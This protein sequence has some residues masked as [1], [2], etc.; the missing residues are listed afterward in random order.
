MHGDDAE[1]NKRTMLRHFRNLVNETALKEH[2]VQ[3]MIRKD[4]GQAKTGEIDQQ[5]SLSEAEMKPIDVRDSEVLDKTVVLSAEKFHMD[6]TSAQ[7]KE[8]HNVFSS[9]AKSSKQEIALS[10]SRLPAPF[11]CS[12]EDRIANSNCE[13]GPSKSFNTQ[14][15]DST[16][17]LVAILGDGVSKEDAASLL[18]LAN[19]DLNA[20][21]NLYYDNGTRSDKVKGTSRPT[22]F[23]KVVGVESVSPITRKSKRTR[24]RQGGK[25]SKI[26]KVTQQAAITTFFA[27]STKEKESHC[28]SEFLDNNADRECASD[29]RNTQNKPMEEKIK[30]KSKR[31]EG[32]QSTDFA[33]KPDKEELKS[34]CVQSD[35]EKGEN[36][37]L[38][39]VPTESSSSFFDSRAYRRMKRTSE[40]VDPMDSSTSGILQQNVQM[41]NDASK[42]EAPVNLSSEKVDKNVDN[43]E[44]GYQPQEERTSGPAGNS[45]ANTEFV[46]LP[47]SQYNPVTMACWKSGEPTPYLHVALSL[48][49][50]DSTT[51]RLRISDALTNMFRSV[52]SLGTMSELIQVTYLTCGRISS[53]YEGR[54]LVKLSDDLCT[55]KFT[56]RYLKFSETVLSESEF[57]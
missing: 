29:K 14:S 52:L 57:V 15:L 6:D 10:D 3:A 51:K 7:Q 30:L 41:E 42:T 11:E 12:V 16:I 35:H 31:D 55:N 23:R 38:P 28:Q 53:E 32:D 47:V 50:I 5:S 48:A 20:A 36:G 13:S 49:S 45:K 37:G 43:E 22:I 4:S 40:H 2:F 9:G 33:S 46:M 19:Y 26:S 56:W 54:T 39:N 1:K 34:Q 27:G 44:T 18:H 25:L 21:V 8:Y 24:E 17:Q